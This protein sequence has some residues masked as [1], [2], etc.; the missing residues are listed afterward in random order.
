MVTTLI[1][2]GKPTPC[3]TC[4]GSPEIESKEI[5]KGEKRERAIR[6]A[7]NSK[8]FKDVLP[9]LIERGFRPSIK[10]AVALLIKFKKSKCKCVRSA[11]VVVIPFKSSHKHLIGIIAFGTFSNFKE[12]IA[13]IVDLKEKKVSIVARSTIIERRGGRVAVEYPYGRTITQGQPCADDSDCP[14]GYLCE[15]KCVEFY[16]PEYD[17]C[18]KG[19]G[20]GFKACL[21][22]C[23]FACQFAGPAFKVCLARCGAAC[24]AQAFNCEVRC[25]QDWCKLWE[26]ECVPR[27]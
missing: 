13:I 10:D 14:P 1:T 17:K 21:G 20:E 11:L 8:V 3:P 26:G 12:A 5:L 16:Q 19:C 6:I 4:G 25:Y 27:S 7:V 9:S 23:A 15:Y 22:A 2:T 24:A 18:R